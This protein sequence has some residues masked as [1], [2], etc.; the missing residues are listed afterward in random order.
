MGTGYEDKFIQ[1]K[2]QKPLN[3]KKLCIFNLGRL[4]RVDC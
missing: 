4:A 3:M 2:I 1:K